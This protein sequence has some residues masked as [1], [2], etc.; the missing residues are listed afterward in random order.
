MTNLAK[1]IF[2]ISAALTL[3]VNSFAQTGTPSSYTDADL[4]WKEEFNGKKLN[5]RDWNYETHEPGWVNAE[6][7]SYGPSTKNTYVKDG[8]LVIQALKKEN[9]DGTVEYTSGR[10]NTMGKHE[11]TYGR[12]EARLRV[13]KGQG[14][15]PAFWMMPGDESYYGQWP[16]CGEIDIMEVMGQE[17]EKLYGTIHYGE[18]H[19]QAQ[20]I[21]YVEAENNFADNFHVFAVEWEPGLMRWYCDGVNYKTVND[22]FTKKPGFGEVAFPAPFDQPFYIILNVAVGGSWVGYPDENTSFDPNTDDAKMYVDYVKV[23]QKKSYNEDVDKPEKAPVVAT[24]DLSGNM[25][26]EKKSSWE[27]LK[28]GGGV[29]GAETDGKNHT[30]TTEKE[31]SLEYSIQYVQPNVPLNMGFKYRY[32]FDAW[33]DEPRTMI[34]GISAPNANYERRFGDVKVNLTTSKQHYSWEFDMM[35]DSDAACRIEYNCGAQDS[36]ATIH[37]TNVRL[38]KIGEIDFAAMGKMSLPDGNYIYNGQFQ[39]GKGRMEHWEVVNNA[40]AKVSVTKDRAR[41]LC[42]ES[43][44]KAKPE[45]VIIK[46]TELEL[47]GGKVYTVKFDAYSSKTCYITAKIGGETLTDRVMA[48]PKPDPSK[49]TAKVAKPKTY[50][51]K[52]APKENVTVD[53]ELLLGTDGATIFLDNVYVKENAVVINGELDRGMSGWELYAHPNASCSSEIID[54][55][56]DKQVSIT[57]DKTGNLDWQIQ[58]KQNGCLLEK[59]KQ[60]KISLK[61]KCDMERTIMLA[62]QRDGSKD[63]DWFPY[64]NTLKF[65]VGPEFQN[66][67]WTFTMGRDTDPNTI[68]TISMGAVSDKII[69][70]KHTIVLDSIS[71]REVEKE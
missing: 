45:D 9:K 28:A 68:F 37:I 57:I 60:Y 52:F 21:H 58:F 31:G 53:L 23:Y 64:S 7:Q 38:E 10:I 48:L 13:P 63:D 50:E 32:S 29:G 51:L 22:W 30:I 56:G 65:K 20:G 1:K 41:M 4:V 49:P 42:V 12:F 3:A 6:L 24:V 62:L 17:P 27:F 43:P 55:D 15:L 11:F 47:E 59:G 66:Y 19:A 39:E 70:K 67:S 33:A 44:K 26:S 35:A 40:G 2:M 71:V 61:A 16:K 54:A 5:A 14:F 34:T 18:P 25:V 8:C 36:R 69:N 46:Q